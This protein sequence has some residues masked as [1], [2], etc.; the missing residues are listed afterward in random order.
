ME[1]DIV[2]E[3]DGGVRFVAD[4]LLAEIFD[5]EQQAT[6]RASFVEPDADL[7]NE[8]RWMADLAPMAGPVL[9]PFRT[10]AVALAAERNW[11]R[12]ERGL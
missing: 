12:Q 10:R 11:L 3:A 5:G 8:T 7:I 9:G 6:R 1:L 2:I 4:D